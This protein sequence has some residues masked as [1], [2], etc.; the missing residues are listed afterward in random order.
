MMKIFLCL[1]SFLL[2]YYKGECAPQPFFPPQI[3]FSPNDGGTIFAIDEVNQRAYQSLQYGATGE[4]TSYVM[5]HFP[6]AIPDS[7]QSKYYVQ[8]IINSIPFDCTYGTYW[9]YGGN[10][11]NMFPSHWWVNRT[12][13][14]VDNYLEFIYEMIHSNDSSVNED[15]WYANVTCKVDSGKNYPCEEIFFEKNTQIPL[16]SARIVRQG[17]KVVQQI[18]NYKIISMGKPDEKYFH[19]IPSNWTSICRDVMLGL[20]Y[21]PQTIKINLNQIAQVQVWLITPPHRIN[22]NDT[23]T[24]QW[25]PSESEWE[26][27]DCFTWTPKQLS[28]NIDNFQEKQT[29]TITRVK[30]GP[31]TTLIPIFNG[32]GFDLVDPVLYP[33][34]IE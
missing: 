4:T 10:I 21:Y 16:R 32:G 23:V 30:N 2:Y 7:P 31:K 8:L 22:G 20:L 1:I 13:F 27:N 18:T 5:K 3:V 19:S 29:L 26:C 34:F 15:Y 28:F 25:K 17:W 33:I 9:K 12:S 14:K 24:I 11:I 6:Y